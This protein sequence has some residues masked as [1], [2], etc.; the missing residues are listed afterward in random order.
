MSSPQFHRSANMIYMRVCNDDL[1]D[2]EL[3]L[4][5]DGENLFDFIAGIDN[6]ALVR[7][8]VTNDG[9]VALQR[10]NRNDDVD[11]SKLPA[12]SFWLLAILNC[13]LVGWNPVAKS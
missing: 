12:T 4:I 9:A 7:A 8:L 6:H 5:D 10:A 2:L 13:A 11:H 1:L 3:M